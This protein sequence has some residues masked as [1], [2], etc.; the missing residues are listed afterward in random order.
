MAHFFI[1]LFF[2]GIGIIQCTK[3][4]IYRTAWFEMLPGYYCSSDAFDVYDYP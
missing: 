2:I 3:E 4:A 1:D